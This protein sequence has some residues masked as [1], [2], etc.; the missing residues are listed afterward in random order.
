M[1]GWLCL[2]MAGW[3]NPVMADMSGHPRVILSASEE[4]S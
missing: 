4:S 1:A 2:V 3:L